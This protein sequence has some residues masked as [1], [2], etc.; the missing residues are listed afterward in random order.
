VL[1][2]HQQATSVFRALA[3]SPAGGAGCVSCSRGPQRRAH[4]AL[5]WRCRARGGCTTRYEVTGSA[6]SP[7]VQDGFRRTTRRRNE[8]RPAP[9]LARWRHA[10]SVN[11]APKRASPHTTAPPH[12]RPGTRY[13]SAKPLSHQCAEEHIFQATSLIGAAAA[14]AMPA[15][16]MH[17][18]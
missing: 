1:P 12:H 2:C 11:P 17:C 18:R 6:R 14:S 8:T 3:T 9:P 4:R 13:R 5:W 7:S 10:R 15:A 16:A